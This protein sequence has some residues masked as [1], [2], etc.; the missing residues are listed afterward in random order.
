LENKFRRFYTKAK[1]KKWCR[2]EM[3][4]RGVGREIFL[5]LLTS[6]NECP[7]MLSLSLSA[8]N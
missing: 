2:K 6:M 7:A 1:M 5:S 8:T 4:N 3:S